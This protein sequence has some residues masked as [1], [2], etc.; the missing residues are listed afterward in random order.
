MDTT[1]NCIIEKEEYEVYVSY[2]KRRLNSLT[3]MQ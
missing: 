1:Q 3:F 2:N